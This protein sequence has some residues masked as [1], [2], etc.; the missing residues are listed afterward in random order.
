M[1]ILSFFE[2]S[3]DL[4]YDPDPVEIHRTDDPVECFTFVPYTL[5]EFDKFGPLWQSV[6]KFRFQDSR[7]EG[8]Y[9]V[10]YRVEI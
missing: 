2:L 5:W 10:E 6:T 4:A 8:V 3:D 7:C 1:F 9:T